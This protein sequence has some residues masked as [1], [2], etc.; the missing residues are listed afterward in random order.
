MIIHLQLLILMHAAGC[1]TACRYGFVVY[2]TKAAAENAVQH[3]N[4]Q[5]L[6]DF[7]GR[8]VGRHAPRAQLQQHGR[9]QE[10]TAMTGQPHAVAALSG[11]PAAQHSSCCA[12]VPCRLSFAWCS[13]S[14]CCCVAVACC[15]A[16]G[17]R[18]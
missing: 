9:N 2:S 8:K 4:A 11:P 17:A 13:P 14:V 18:E 16:A 3:L 5:E 1:W 10:S 7:P 15:P 6:P 12:Y